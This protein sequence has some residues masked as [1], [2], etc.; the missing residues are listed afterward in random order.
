METVPEEGDIPMSTDPPVRHTQEPPVP[1]SE[2]ASPNSGADQQPGPSSQT[3][4]PATGERG[5]RPRLRRHKNFWVE[6]FPDP[7]AGAPISKDR[8]PPID[9]EAHMRSCGHMANPEHFET[10]ELLSTSGMTDAAK[11]RHLKSSK[12]RGQTPWCNVQNMHSDV[13]KLKHGPPFELCDIDISDGKRPRT[14]YLIRRDIIK[15]TRQMMADPTQ[16]GSFKTRPAKVWTSAARKER[17]W[18]E[19]CYSEWW[20]NEQEK[21]AKEGH[22]DATIVP[23]ILATDQTMLSVMCGGQKAYPLY[24][25]LANSSKRRRRKKKKKG[26]AVAGYLPV[27]AFEDIENN[28]ERRRLKADLVHRSMG[29]I[30]EPLREASKNGIEMW[31]P[32]GRLR[33]VFPRIAA[34]VAD[35][36][37]QNLQSCTSEG[38]CPICKTKYAGRGDLDQQAELRDCE[39]TLGVLRGYFA[40]KRVAE[41]RA[42]SLKPVWPWWGDIPELNL[43]TCFMLDLLHQ[44]HQGIF[45]TH[46]LRWLRHLVGDKKLDERLAAMPRAEGLRHFHKGVTGVQQWT[47]RESKQIAAQLLPVVAGTLSSELINMVRSLIDF[48]FRAQ[49]PTMT[50]TDI[51]AMERDLARF[52]ELKDLLIAKGVYKSSARFDKIPKLHMLSHYTYLIRQMGTPDGFSTET[53]EYLHIE[54]AKEPWRASNKVRPLPQMLTYLQ[55]QEAIRIHRAYL[56]A[57]LGLDQDED[58]EDDEGEYFDED[59]IDEGEE[60]VEVLELRDEEE[61]DESQTAVNDNESLLGGTSEPITYPD[62]NRHMAKNPTKQNVS[63]REVIDNYGASDIIPAITAFLGHRL[64]VPA[65]DVL[66]SPHNYVDVWH[67]LYLYHKPLDFAPFDPRRRD[68]V[69]ASPAVR[70]ARNRPRSEPVWDVA[71]YS[72]RPNRLRSSQDVYEKHGI[73]R[74]R[75]GRVHAFFTLP[76]HLK[77]L[78]SGQLAYVEVF[79]PFDASVSPFTGMHSTCP[80]YDSRNRRRTLVIPVSDIALACHLAPK[81]H[82]LDPELKLATHM[83][84]FAISKHF[85]LNHYYNNNFFR[86]I[87]HWRH[88]RPRML[89]RLL[90]LVR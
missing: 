1:P 82:L 85:W 36:P 81:F 66:I 34:Y 29:R 59:D 11:D 65:H 39:E 89:D 44:V 55:R 79:T 43:A 71:L 77:Y 7:L 12:Y 64:S 62:P 10:A 40:Q 61:C 50:D 9:L 48:A 74:Y 38:S 46:L 60:T 14:Q 4:T 83:D 90:Q 56:D 47:G 25:S 42:L 6:D 68:V 73:Q 8:V 49:A 18:G 52:H 35:W 24:M 19:S 5:A 21:L 16:K 87:Q 75:A 69:R 13:D 27:D 23:L 86:L 70:G 67:K 2:E 84:L 72:E 3:R 88:R 63:I 53:P 28:E 31:C 45:K 26:T 41:L 15:I 32:D 58:D 76:G 51:A 22:R 30:L 33:R 37:E 54:Y 78:F 57:Y 80:D 17:V 20:W